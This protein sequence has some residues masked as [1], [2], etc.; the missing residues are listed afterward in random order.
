MVH[1]KENQANPE[2]CLEKF[3]HLVELLYNL[4]LVDQ[5]LGPML[6]VLS[7]LDSLF[8]SRPNLFLNS[9]LICIIGL[10]EHDAL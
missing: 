6:F 2:L 10:G 4:S 3:G 5:F 8:K 9:T 7:G 1:E